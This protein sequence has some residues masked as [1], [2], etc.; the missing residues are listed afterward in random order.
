ML[1][2][3]TGEERSGEDTPLA[4]FSVVC[5]LSAVCSVCFASAVYRQLLSSA[6][7]VVFVPR[8]V[9]LLLVHL[10]LLLV[11]LVL[12]ILLRRLLLLLPFLPFLLVLLPPC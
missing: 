10:P 12:L 5:L 1:E 7:V 6:S 4:V 11:L 2:K 3:R 8:L 9:L